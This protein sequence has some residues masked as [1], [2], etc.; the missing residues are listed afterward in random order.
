[1]KRSKKNSEKATRRTLRQ[2]LPST[3]S[4]SLKGSVWN[5]RRSKRSGRRRRRERLLKEPNFSARN[6]KKKKLQPPKKLY[7]CPKRAK[8]Q[9]HQVLG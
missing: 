2:L 6:S 7:N 3:K 4:S 8:E 9:L 5:E 1:V